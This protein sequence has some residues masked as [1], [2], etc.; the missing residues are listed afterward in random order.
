MLSGR[1]N[2]DEIGSTFQDYSIFQESND[3]CR[4]SWHTELS[5]AFMGRPTNKKPLVKLLR[6]GASLRMHKK[7]TSAAF[8]ENTNLALLSTQ[9]QPKIKV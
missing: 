5:N 9:H 1:S 7:H 3:R 6:D 4:E 8:S 2:I